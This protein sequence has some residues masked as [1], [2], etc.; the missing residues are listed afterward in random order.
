MIITPRQHCF[1]TVNYGKYWFEIKLSWQFLFSYIFCK[2]LLTGVFF[3]FLI[4]CFL[5][6]IT[7]VFSVRF[8]FPLALIL[9][10][11]P[12][13]EWVSKCECEFK[14]EWI[15]VQFKTKL[16]KTNQTLHFLYKY[17]RILSRMLCA[18]SLSLF[19][20]NQSSTRT[21][22]NLKISSCTYKQTLNCR[23]YRNK[24]KISTTILTCGS[25]IFCFYFR[26]RFF[27]YFFFILKKYWMRGACE[28]HKYGEG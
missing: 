10:L 6:K 3:F 23:L 28:S 14:N 22:K 7:R 18:C 2:L 5:L 20:N 25:V 13:G 21:K 11:L 4:C 17:E 19:L 1:V 9:L 27:W 12:T 26:F 15:L 16:N 8:L 24:Q